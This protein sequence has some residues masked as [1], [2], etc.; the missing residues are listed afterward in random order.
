MVGLA[1]A[2]GEKKTDKLIKLKKLAK[3]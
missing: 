1:V 3:K 2:S